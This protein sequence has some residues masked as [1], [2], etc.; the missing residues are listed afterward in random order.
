M[1]ATRV[2]TVSGLADNIIPLHTSEFLAMAVADCNDVMYASI[3]WYN[4]L[5]GSQ[6]SAFVTAEG[7]G[8]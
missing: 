7:E 1:G 6:W 8:S 4:L 3:L 2:L 5:G